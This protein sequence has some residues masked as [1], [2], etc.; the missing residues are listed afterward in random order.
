[1]YVFPSLSTAIRI[2]QQSFLNQRKVCI[3]SD[4]TA[5]T[6]A[7]AF[8]GRLAFEPWSLTAGRLRRN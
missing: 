5:S 3:S 6:T 8:L 7:D 2:R 1:M 4:S